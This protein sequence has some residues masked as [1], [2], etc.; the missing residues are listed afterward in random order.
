MTRPKGSKNKYPRKDKGT[1][2]LPPKNV[3]GG[4]T[5]TET[6]INENVV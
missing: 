1:T 4:A 6:Q 5:A 3:E 2:K